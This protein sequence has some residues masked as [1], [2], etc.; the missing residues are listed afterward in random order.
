MNKVTI[1]F[2]FQKK[3]GVENFAKFISQLV[4]EG[5]TFEVKNDEF[6]AEVTL[7]GGF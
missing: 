6:G 2:D 1:R 3:K 5:V 7:T 4:R